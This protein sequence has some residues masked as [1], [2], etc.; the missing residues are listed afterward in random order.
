LRAKDGERAGAGAVGFFVAAF[1]NKP[2]QI[3]VLAHG[4]VV[5]SVL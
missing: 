3:V 4:A 1:K 2:E 5:K